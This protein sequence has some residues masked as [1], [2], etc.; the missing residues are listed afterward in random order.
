MSGR[1]GDQFMCPFQCD[2]CVFRTV[3][4]RDPLGPSAADERLLACIRRVILDSFWARKPGTVEANARQLRHG[5]KM[6]A[7]LG[8]DPPC[9]RMGP[10]Q[11]EDSWG[12]KVALAMVEDSLRPGRYANYKQFKATRKIRTAFAE[13]VG[14][15]GRC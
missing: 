5:V 3:Q 1:S 14:C 13:L 12:Y 7:N 2:L 9:T 11:L 15:F 10:F 4:G 6:M 8:V